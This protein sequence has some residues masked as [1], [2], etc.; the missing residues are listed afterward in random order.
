MGLAEGKMIAT[1]TELEAE[2]RRRWP[3][4]RAIVGQQIF[5]QGSAA[6]N[7]WSLCLFAGS[8]SDPKIVASAHAALTPDAAL[9][10]VVA[11]MDERS[12]DRG[13]SWA[14]DDPP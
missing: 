1:L 13:Q 14:T 6:N 5:M 2:V 4:L 7:W 3:G 11:T 9:A 12:R 8:P 10:S